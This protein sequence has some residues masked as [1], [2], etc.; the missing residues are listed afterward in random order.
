M[1]EQGIKFV[2]EPKKAPYGTVA[3]LEDPYSNLRDLVQFT[4]G[5]D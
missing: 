3:V 1:V 4:D 5:R 2:R